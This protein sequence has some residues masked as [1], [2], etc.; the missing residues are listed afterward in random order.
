MTKVR[1]KAAAIALRQ[2]GN[3][4]NA[5]ALELHVAKSSVSLWVRDIYLLD[6]AVAKIQASLSKGQRASRISKRRTTARKL[7]EANVAA[8]KIVERVEFEK[9]IFLLITSIL[10]WCEGRK[11][12]NDD[13]LT[14]SNSDPLVI[15]G[16]LNSLRNSFS[17]QESRF[18]VV[19]HL[20][21]YHS[22]ATQRSYWSSQTKIPENQFSK[23]F[24]KPHTGKNIRPGYPGCIHIKYYDVTVA[25]AVAAAA[26]AFL[27][28]A[29]K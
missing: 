25:R 13:T 24:W 26:R 10:Y 28:K 21:E 6:T 19:M 3:S 23:T 22:E 16:Y 2:L 20:H 17:I 7:Y 8:I 14:F 1:E 12:K 27:G 15:R 29:S 18:R 5:I 9:E 4:I 11:S